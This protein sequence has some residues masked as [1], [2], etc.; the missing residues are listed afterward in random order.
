[1]YWRSPWANGVYRSAARAVIVGGCYRSGTTLMRAILDSHPHI[2]M[3]PESWLFVYRPDYGSLAADYDLPISYV[4]DLHRRSTCLA[5]FIDLFFEAYAQRRGKTKWGEKSPPNVLRLP[6]IWQRFPNA[7]FIHMVRDGRD[8]IC[9]MRSQHR[10][11]VAEGFGTELK[12]FDECLRWWISCV[13]AGIRWRGD[14]RYLEVKYEELVTGL[15]NTM[16]RVLDFLGEPW[17]DEVIRAHEV[18]RNHPHIGYERGTPE[19]R[20]PI[21]QSSMG[22]WRKDLPM[23]EAKRFSQRA[24]MLLQRLGYTR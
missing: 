16:A 22:R 20:E 4:M 19:V 11:L 9:S 17:S 1:M 15:R 24:E 18:Q 21:F 3:G 7:R 5:N 14:P 10:R 6:W 2:A 8:V 13:R 23:H 12:G